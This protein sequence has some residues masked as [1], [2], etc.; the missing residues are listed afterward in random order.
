VSS[1]EIERALSQQTSWGNTEEPHIIEPFPKLNI[2]LEDAATHGVSFLNEPPQL[3]LFDN[4]APIAKFGSSSFHNELSTSLILLS[5]KQQL[6]F[7]QLNPLYTSTEHRDEFTWKIPL[8]KKGWAIIVYS[9][10]S[11]GCQIK[12]P[13]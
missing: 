5:T 4:S 11:T 8:E 1:A 10:P 12:C 13:K 7:P 9:L 6:P 2:D 3:L